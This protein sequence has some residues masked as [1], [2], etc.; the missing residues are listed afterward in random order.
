MVY[1]HTSPDSV[2]VKTHPEW[3]YYKP[4]GKRGNR[5]GWTDI[6]DLDY[7]TVVCGT[8]ISHQKYWAHYV[9]GYQMWCGLHGTT[10]FWQ[11]AL[12]AVKAQVR[13]GLYQ[14]AESVHAE[15]IKA[16]ARKGRGG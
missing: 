13:G 10:D 4:D 3:F 6:V 2:L 5:V 8:Q 16:T 14:L 1:N 15:F 12:Q 9:D 7:R 11:E